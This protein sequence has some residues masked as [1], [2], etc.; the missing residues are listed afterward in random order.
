MPFNGFENLKTP[1]C[2]ISAEFG[3]RDA[4]CLSVGAANAGC[5]MRSAERDLSGAMSRV[6]G[7]DSQVLGGGM[8]PIRAGVG[9]IGPIF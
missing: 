6:P 3:V 5:G 1:E 4:E 7:A 8:R 2:R 9:T